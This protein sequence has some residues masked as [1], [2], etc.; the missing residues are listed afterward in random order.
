MGWLD[1]A[2]DLGG[3]SRHHSSHSR[4]HSTNGGW[5]RRP[6]P[7]RHHSTGS[8]FGSG[9]HHHN[10]STRSFFSFGG[11]KHHRR[12]SSR[13]GYIKKL[14]AQLRRLLRDLV[15]YMKKHPM[16]VFVL[17]I[18]PLLTGGAL[19]GLL[20]R[21]GIRL[22]GGLDKM[23]GGA[24]GGHGYGHG[25]SSLGRDSRGNMQWERS[26]VSGEGLGGWMGGAGGL[27]SMAKMF[28]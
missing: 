19:S 17:V 24:A 8:I 18:M 13:P 11:G 7:S 27:M 12:A 1:A 28:I 14:Y 15:Y 25:S 26:T 3:G 16:K 22:P 23:F 6:S 21:F 2:S 9:S 10:A 5:V 4:S 20:Q